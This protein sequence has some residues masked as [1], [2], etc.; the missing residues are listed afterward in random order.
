MV[1][2]SD[3]NV[4]ETVVDELLQGDIIFMNILGTRMVVLNSL[5]A[6]ND[7][8]EKRSSKYSGRPHS[9]MLAEL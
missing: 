8:L 5:S 4:A 7:L 6:C 9:V 1:S 2:W 3:T